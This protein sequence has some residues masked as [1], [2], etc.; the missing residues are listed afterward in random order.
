MLFIDPDSKLAKVLMV[1]AVIPAATVVLWLLV[2][3]FLRSLRSTNWPTAPG[4]ILESRVEKP[5][6]N[7]HNLWGLFEA[8]KVTIRYQYVVAG[9]Q[10]END[11][12][13]FGLASESGSR[14]RAGQ[15]N[16]KFPKGQLVDVHYD[17]DRPEVSCLET[18]I[19]D[20]EDF[21]VLLFA[22]LGICLGMKIFG[23]FLKWLL[24]P[25]KLAIVK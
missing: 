22:L 5:D 12:I 21:I 24:R 20:W 3:N 2:A 18:G 10:M 16:A 17:P 19:L 6:P 11:T 15:K 8:S 23:D 13:S 14:G 4:L 25:R 1:V 9:R 7:P